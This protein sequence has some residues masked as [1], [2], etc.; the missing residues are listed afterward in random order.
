MIIIIIIIIINNN[1]NKPHL[2]ASRWE[3]A[4]FTAWHRCKTCNGL[5]MFSFCAIQQ[6]KPSGGRAHLRI[7]PQSPL[8]S[9]SA[10]HFSYA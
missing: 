5:G 9:S 8:N 4:L 6:V 7:L 10:V 3:F 1:N 2:Y